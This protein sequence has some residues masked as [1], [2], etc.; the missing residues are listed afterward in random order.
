VRFVKLTDIQDHLKVAIR[1]DLIEDVQEKPG[2]TVVSFRATR[3]DS[4]D[5]EACFYEVEESFAVVMMRIEEAT[6]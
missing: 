4:E 2:G 6:R 5:S 1:V 3:D